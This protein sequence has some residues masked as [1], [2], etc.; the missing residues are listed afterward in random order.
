MMQSLEAEIS[1][2]LDSRQKGS[3][4]QAV[5]EKSGASKPKA[6]QNSGPASGAQG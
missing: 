4:L 3:D 2:E 6:T 1:P 5:Q